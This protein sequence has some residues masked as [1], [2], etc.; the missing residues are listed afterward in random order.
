MWTPTAWRQHS[1]AGLRYHTDL[2]DAE[3]AVL[4]PLMPA[5]TTGGH[6]PLWRAREVLIAIFYVLQGGLA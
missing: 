1:R 5:P 6:P 4:K 3:S 2:T